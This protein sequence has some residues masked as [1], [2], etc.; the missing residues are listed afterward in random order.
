MNVNKNANVLRVMRLPPGEQVYQEM[1]PESEEFGPGPNAGGTPVPLS[2]G[3][4]SRSMRRTGGAGIGLTILGV[5]SGLGCF[6]GVRLRWGSARS[7]FLNASAYYCLQG[8]LLR[9]S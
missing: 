3:T 2:L 7:N 5:T 9:L 8:P 1:P 4:V 6:G